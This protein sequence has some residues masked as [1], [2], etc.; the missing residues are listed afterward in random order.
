M[1]VWPFPVK[2][3]AGQSRRTDEGWDLQAAG[4]IPVPV[5]AVA[6]GTLR[7]AGP[8]PNG[9]G[10]SYPL[11]LLDT[12]IFGHSAIY[13]GHT[14]PDWRKVGRHVSAGEEIGHTGGHHSGGN[15]FNDPNWLE[16]GFWPPAFANGPAMKAWLSGSRASPGGPGSSS[17]PGG[18]LP[19]GQAVANIVGRARKGKG[20][21]GPPPQAV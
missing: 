13:Y 4:V 18:C 15:A 16:I 7:T 21:K 12:P 14:F 5:L 8:D 11:L 19:G 3:M 10:N 2:D 6:A 1:P 9:F 17:V 20:G